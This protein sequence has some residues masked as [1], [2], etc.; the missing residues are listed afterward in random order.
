MLKNKILTHNYYFLGL[1]IDYMV[2]LFQFENYY[3][4]NALNKII[5]V[6]EALAN[7]IE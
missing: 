7:T 5:F 6:F 4:V 2:S 1:A 3:L